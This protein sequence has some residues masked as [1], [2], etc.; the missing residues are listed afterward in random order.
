MLTLTNVNIRTDRRVR[1]TR[2][3]RSRILH[4]KITRK[5]WRNFITV[6]CTKTTLRPVTL[7]GSWHVSDSFCAGIE[8]CSISW[9]KLVPEKTGTRLTDTR[10]SFLYKTTCTSFWY[11]FLERVSPPLD[12]DIVRNVQCQYAILLS[13]F[14][15][16]DLQ[17]H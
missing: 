7:H 13:V 5:I 15:V 16:D 1:R 11:K 9:K 3:L 12:W 10:A 4:Q 17:E 2:D 14:H 6:F 8:L